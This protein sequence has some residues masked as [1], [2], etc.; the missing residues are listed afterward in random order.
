MYTICMCV[1]AGACRVQRDV[2]SL[3][4]GV[5]DDYE[6]PCG[7]WEPKRGPLQFLQPQNCVF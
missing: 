2:R 5:T 1:C 3:G 4:A 6:P 7:F